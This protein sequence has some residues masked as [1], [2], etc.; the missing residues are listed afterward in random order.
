MLLIFDYYTILDVP[1]IVSSFHTYHSTKIWNH[2]KTKNVSLPWGL[3]K[4]LLFHDKCM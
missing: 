1:Y 3:K 4:Y 2:Y